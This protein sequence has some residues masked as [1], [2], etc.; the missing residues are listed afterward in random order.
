MKEEFVLDKFVVDT[1]IENDLD[2]S[3]NT[4]ETIRR[5][6]DVY[7]WG[8]N[9]LWPGLFANAGPCNARVGAEGHFNSARATPPTDLAAAL[10]AKG[11]N[12]D[13]WPDGSGSYHLDG[14]KGF[15]VPELADAMDTFDWSEGLSIRQTR[16]GHKRPEDCST[17][18]ISGRCATEL[19]ELALSDD[20]PFGFN[21]T[22]PAASL[23]N[24]WV[25][26]TAAQLGANPGG[27]MSAH[28]ASF[29]TFELG[30]FA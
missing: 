29:R 15:T 14:A 19:D 2:A 17:L 18:L 25:Y 5:V 8:N 23:S 28:Q 3:H 24:P 7:E 26:K 6:A 22:H 4:F 21:W 12:D 13:V 20:R 16:V 9:V 10:A 30:G 1:L 27:Q 11:C